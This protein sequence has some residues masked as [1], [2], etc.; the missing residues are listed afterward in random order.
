MLR[1]RAEDGH[2]FTWSDAGAPALAGATLVI[3][4]VVIVLLP[5]DR[6]N[7]LSAILGVA[8]V[9]AGFLVVGEREG[10]SI[11]AAFIVTVL[12]AAFL[13][14]ASAAATAIIA[15]LTA[16]L[17]LRTRWRWVLLANLPTAVVSAVAAATIIQALA[18]QPADDLDFYL[19]VA[20]AGTTSML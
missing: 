15:E 1:R 19:S 10:A 9:G 11:S 3:C 16:A 12:A 14:P 17:R 4:A 20:L 8:A 5:P 7:E 2:S 6:V 13:G 18:P